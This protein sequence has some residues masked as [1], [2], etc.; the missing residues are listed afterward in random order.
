[1]LNLHRTQFSAFLSLDAQH[2]LLPWSLL[3]GPAISPQSLCSLGINCP[4]ALFPVW[5]DQALQRSPQPANS[6][7]LCLPVHL[8]TTTVPARA[9]LQVRNTGL[10]K[11]FSYCQY[12]V[13]PHNSHLGSRLNTFPWTGRTLMAWF[14]SQLH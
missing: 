4:A 6:A 13:W 10:S 5:G 1:M 2:H 14:K 7:L 8:L 12:P 3:S 11:H 9:V